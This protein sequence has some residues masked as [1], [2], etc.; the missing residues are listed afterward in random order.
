VRRF[1]EKQMFV[2]LIF[3]VFGDSL[4]LGQVLGLH[5]TWMAGHFADMGL[6]AQCTTALYYIFGRVRLGRFIAALLPPVL[7]ILYEYSQLPNA[8]PADV[9]SYCVGSAVASLSIFL[10]VVANRKQQL[11]EVENT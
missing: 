6:P 1:L 11:M 2:I 9:A 10:F 5:Y 3:I 7:F 4:K 8:D